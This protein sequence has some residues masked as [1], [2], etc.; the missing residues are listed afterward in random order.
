MVFLAYERIWERFY[1]VPGVEKQPGVGPSLGL[2]LYICRMITEQHTGQVGVMST[3]G[4]GSTFWFTPPLKH[5]PR[6]SRTSP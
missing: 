3:P 6:T 4:H 5:Q 2:G 1:R